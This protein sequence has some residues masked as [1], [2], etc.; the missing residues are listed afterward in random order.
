MTLPDPIRWSAPSGV[1]AGA[2]C[3]DGHF[4]GNPIVPGAVLLAHAAD[5]LHGQ[6]Q[7]IVAIR[8]M[9]FLRPLGPGVPFEVQIDP[10]AQGARITWRSGGET[11]ADARV[12][13]RD[14]AGG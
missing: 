8:R 4:P 10:S 5:V 2:S 1:P 3:L 14:L 6:G 7:A 13:L 12:S 9:K 11:L